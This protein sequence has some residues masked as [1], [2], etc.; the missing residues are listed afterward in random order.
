VHGWHAAPTPQ[1]WLSLFIAQVAVGPT[2]HLWR[3][4]A[5]AENEHANTPVDV[6]SQV[7]MAVA[8]TPAGRAFAHGV[9]EVPQAATLFFIGHV[10]GSAV[11]VPPHWWRSVSQTTVQAVPLH[12]RVPPPPMIS[13]QGVQLAPQVAVALLLLHIGLAVVPPQL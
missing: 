7:R 4:S 2:P 10:G 13:T 9:Q 8:A 5:Q 6:S 12:P 3:P 11:V 1:F